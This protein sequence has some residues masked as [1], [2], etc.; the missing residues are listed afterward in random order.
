[1]S[2]WTRQEAMSNWTPQKNCQTELFSGARSNWTHR[3]TVKLT[4]LRSN[5]KLNSSGAMSN[6]TSSG[7]L[8]NW[9]PRVSMSNWLFS[10]VMSNWTPQENCQTKLLRSMSNWTP[11]E[12]CQTELLRRTVKL[13][14]SGELCV[15]LNS[16]EEP[17]NWTLL[18]SNVKL[19]S[20]GVSMSN[21]TLQ[22]NCQ[23]ELLRCQCQT[24]PPQE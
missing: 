4:F 12:N 14:S 7:E 2:N 10:G 17:S 19:N 8:S 20:S 5:V 18:R 13:N 23:T 1:M 21:W 9:T 22:E 16:S 11:Q 3:R 24:E 6:W 15:K